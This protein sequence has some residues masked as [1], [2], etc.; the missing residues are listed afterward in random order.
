MYLHLLHLLSTQTLAYSHFH[1]FPHFSPSSFLTSTCSSSPLQSHSPCHHSHTLLTS[2]APPSHPLIIFPLFSLETQLIPISPHYFSTHSPPPLPLF[3]FIS[4]P[5]SYLSSTFL[6]S[7]SI[8]WDPAHP[9]FP[10]FTS[11][12]THLSSSC[13]PLLLQHFSSSPLLILASLNSFSTC[14]PLPWSTPFTHFSPPSH[15]P[16][17]SLITASHT[18]HPVLLTLFQPIPYITLAS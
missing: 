16:H 11:L 6:I 14:S 9:H 3:F 17:I 2:F 13:H 18:C 7:T 4:S 1:L 10:L 12:Y 15:H 8:S 5:N